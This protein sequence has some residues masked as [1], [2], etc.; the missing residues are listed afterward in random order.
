LQGIGYI[1]KKGKNEII[2]KKNQIFNKKD[3]KIKNNTIKIYKQIN[4]FNN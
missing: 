1:E 2:W 4:E 3:I